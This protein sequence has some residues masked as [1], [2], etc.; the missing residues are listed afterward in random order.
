MKNSKIEVIQKISDSYY[1]QPNEK[2][3][4]TIL[5]LMSNSDNCVTISLSK[6]SLKI[7]IDPN[8]VWRI[9]TSLVKKKYIKRFDSEI[10][11]RIKTYEILI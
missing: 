1:L 3:V 8:S 2:C 9:I 6:L 4:M 11:K 5:S 7:N 10:D